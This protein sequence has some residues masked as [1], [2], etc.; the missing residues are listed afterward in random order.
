MKLPVENY[1]DGKMVKRIK[2]SQIGEK[3]VLLVEKI[4]NLT[5]R[6]LQATKS[7]FHQKP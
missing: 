1:G 5:S 3:A 4:F 2:S 6:L 7:L